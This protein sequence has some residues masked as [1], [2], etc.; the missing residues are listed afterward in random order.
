ME[1]TKFRLQFS[2]ALE[3]IK[4]HLWRVRYRFRKL[5]RVA[6][7]EARRLGHEV[8]ERGDAL[9]RLLLTKCRKTIFAA[10]SK[11][12]KAKAQLSLGF[13]QGT[14]RLRQAQ[15]R[16][17]GLGRNVVHKRRRR[18]QE[19][20]AREI[21]MHELLADSPDAIA[22]IN[23]DHRFVTANRRALDLFGVS[24][25]NLSKFNIDVFI[26]RGQISDLQR[27]GSL[28]MGRQERHG[29]CMIRRFDGSLQVAEFAFVTDFVPPLHLCRFYDLRMPQRLTPVQHRIQPGAQHS[30]NAG[31]AQ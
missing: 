25:K 6:A 26:Y 16:L 18:R 23:G 14:A 15:K 27:N 12:T 5:K 2:I 30:S 17:A 31:Q 9:R 8:R 13:E 19:I 10:H 20:G 24:E 28:F 22:V 3:Q 29:K 1:I 11:G 4:V 21:Q 7:A